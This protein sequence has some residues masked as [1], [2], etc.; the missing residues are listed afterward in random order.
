MFRPRER[1]KHKATGGGGC[2]PLIAA[3]G[4]LLLG[5]C[6]SVL[7][8]PPGARSVSSAPRA[9][10]GEPEAARS[11]ATHSYDQAKAHFLAGSLGLAL[12]DFRRSLRSDPES[13]PTLNGIA[14]TYA[15]L[16][17]FDLSRHYY[18]RALAYEPDSAATL[19]NF[20]RSLLAHDQALLAV[21]YLE[22][23]HQAAPDNELIQANLDLARSLASRPIPQASRNRA[24][25]PT[26]T[27]WVERTDRRIQTLVTT[28]RPD[29]RDPKANLR[30]V[31]VAPADPGR[32]SP[33]AAPR[34]TTTE[35]SNGAGRRHMAAR[36]R[37]YLGGQGIG[38][39]RLT[40]ASHF[41][42]DRSVIFYLEGSEEQAQRL[43]ALLPIEVRLERARQ[44]PSEVRLRLGA[45]LLDFDA[46][47][48]SRGH[49]GRG[50]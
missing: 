2:R 17:R 3:L 47:L 26:P 36:M 32:V 37:Q 48:S 12:R 38:V 20:G 46:L 18:E 8:Q 19:N 7:E 11:S 30:L 23:A 31:H 6:A 49:T 10:Q 39:G 15:R 35:V 22:R 5:G 24:N 28:P 42:F 43:A 25:G 34:A 21:G 33:A 4:L 41:N 27:V 44:Q 40:N 13:V 45:D 50:S 9:S 16:G 29:Q 14:I 1:S